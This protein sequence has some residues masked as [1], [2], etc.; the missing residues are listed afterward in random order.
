MRELH[1]NQRSL[2]VTDPAQIDL[3]LDVT[4]AQR[5][6]V[7]MGREHTLGTAAEELSI[8]A[9]SLAYWVKRLL[10]AKLI[11]ITRLGPRAGR[12]IP[13][14]RAVADEFI[15]PFAAMP[16]DA[17][18]RFVGS[19]RSLM[20]EKFTAA[21]DTSRRDS[22]TGAGVRLSI[23][24]NRHLEFGVTKEDAPLP[25]KAIESWSEIGLTT[26]EHAELSKAL[27]DLIDRFAIGRPTRGRKKYL[28][29]VGLAPAPTRTKSRQTAR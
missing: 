9:S 20:Y 17:H 8:P 3:L 29:V 23:Q 1:S 10:R 14:Y 18:E 25:A 5:V 12:A 19:A 22:R 28:M 11:T 26:E 6:G 4:A 21:V 24:P 27:D 13:H 7:F 2:T 16:P 15:I